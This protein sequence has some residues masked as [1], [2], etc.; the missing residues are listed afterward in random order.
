MSKP[1]SEDTSALLSKLMVKWEADWRNA[2]PYLD[3]RQ[4]YYMQ[5]KMYRDPAT[6]PYKY[7]PCSPLVFSITENTTATYFNAYFSNDRVTQVLPTEKSHAFSPEIQDEKIARQLEIVVNAIQLHPDRQYEEDM[8]DLFQEVSLYGNAYSMCVPEFDE[9]GKY[10]GPR[11]KHISLFDLVPDRRAYRISNSEHLWHIERHVSKEELMSR[12]ESPDHNGYIKMKEKDIEMLFTEPGWI[13]EDFKANL[14]SSLGYEDPKQLGGVNTENGEIIIIH[15]YDVRTGH[16][17]SIAGNRMIVR[18]T[19]VPVELPGLGGGSVKMAIPPFYYNPYDHVKHWPFP[20]EW[21]AQGVGSIAGGFQDDINLLKSMRLENLELALHKVF[22]VNE[23]FNIDVDDLYFTPGGVIPVSDLDRA[24]KVLDTG[25]EITR[26][27]YL[28]EAEWQ[29]EAQDAAS[30]QDTQRGNATQRREAATTV[31]ALNEGAMKRPTAFLKRFRAWDR[32]VSLKK[33]LQIRQYMTQEDYQMIIGEEDAGFF[34]MPLDRVQEMF[35]VS[36]ATISLSMAREGDKQNLVQFAQMFGPMNIL[37]PNA[38]GELGMELFFPTK[39]P[40]RYVITAEEQE[41]IQKQAAEAA[42]Q[43]AAAGIPPD[44]S[45][46]G[47][48]NPAGATANGP[49]PVDGQALVDK[50]SA[51]G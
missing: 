2:R 5:Y 50:A 19:T 36:P 17:V 44:G 21:Y 18:D 34:M 47:P 7:N 6:H 20:K 23:G 25:P 31:V 10:L 28:E 24:I 16:Y 48:G 38:W 41:A 27:A 1:T 40:G 46:G 9:E 3:E 15:H 11:V 35:D 14:L 4:A 29:K 12:M 30:N 42:A 26:D 39:N 33:I 51:G 8:Y 37:K 49:Q 22:L 43:Q 13:H 45:Q 32:S